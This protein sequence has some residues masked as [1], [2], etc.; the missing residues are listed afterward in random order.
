MRRFEG[1]EEKVLSVLVCNACGKR[2]IVDRGIAR[3][4]NVALNC[5][6]DYFS[7]K[8]GEKHEFD[9]CEE[10][11]DRIISQFAIPVKITEELVLI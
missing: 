6:W 3:E 8:D 9:L 10:C 5:S 2:L 11:Y 4:G 1:N 7:E